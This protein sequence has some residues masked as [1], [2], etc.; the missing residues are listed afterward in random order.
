MQSVRI[1]KQ[2]LQISDPFIFFI[3]TCLR[4]PWIA[5]TIGHHGEGGIDG[6][7][8][9]VKTYT[10]CWSRAV[11]SRWTWAIHCLSRR[12]PSEKCCPLSFCVALTSLSFALLDVVTSKERFFS[13]VF[14]TKIFCFIWH[15]L[16]AEKPA[17]FCL[18]LS[19]KKGKIIVSPTQCCEWADNLKVLLLKTDN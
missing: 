11:A 4:G 10:S 16:R 13:Q 14:Q 8:W 17:A 15:L 7:R 1:W 18:I 2:I 19:K 6:P 12:L 3:H 5:V 9:P